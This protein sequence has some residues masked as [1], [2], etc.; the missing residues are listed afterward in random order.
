MIRRQFLGWAARAG[1]G[2]LVAIET[3]GCSQAKAAVVFRVERFTCVT[4]AAGLE[5]LLGR[6]R[7]VKTVTATYPEGMARVEYDA[8]ATTAE[9]LAGAIGEM[10]FRATLVG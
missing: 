8:G 1:A 4:C 9:T 7:G 6:E 3:A 10:G 5:T 2:G